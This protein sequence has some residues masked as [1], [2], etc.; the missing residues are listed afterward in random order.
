MTFKQAVDAT[1]D[2]AGAWQPGLQAL[3][4]VHRQQIQTDQPNK[5]TGSVN[6]EKCLTQKY[7]ERHQWDYAVGFNPTNIRDEVVY[8]LEVHPATQ[9]RAK[10]MLEKLDDLK[11][12]LRD[13]GR[14]LDRFRGQF[15]W[16]SSGKTSLTPKSP[17]MKRLAAAGLRHVG[18][19]FRIP[20]EFPD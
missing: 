18:R 2:V 16:I 12:W 9:G 13:G 4:K 19:V 8:W 14:Q 17:T 15:I 10:E 5:L 6:V 3:R 20:A 7:A 1:P 11:S